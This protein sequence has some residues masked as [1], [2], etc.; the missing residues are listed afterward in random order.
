MLT[1]CIS[2]SILAETLHYRLANYYNWWK[3][4]RGYKDSLPYA[5]KSHVNSQ[6]L[7]KKKLYFQNVILL[8]LSFIE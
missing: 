8:S 5:L 2:A 4:G 3:L 7:P 1:N 6:L